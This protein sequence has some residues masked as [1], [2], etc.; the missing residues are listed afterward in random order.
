MLSFIKPFISAV[1]LPPTSLFLL[2]FL[3]LFLM[4]RKKS[5]K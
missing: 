5:I 2:I 1:I 3:G 4:G